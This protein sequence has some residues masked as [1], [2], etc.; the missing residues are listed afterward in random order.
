MTTETKPTLS[1][2]RLLIGAGAGGAVLAAGACG[3]VGFAARAQYEAELA[4]LRTLVGLYQQLEKVG[5]DGV[6]ASGMGV[7][8]AALDAVKTGV[9]LLRDGV[10]AVETAIKNFQG[11]LDILKTAANNASQ[12]LTEVIQ[13]TRAVEGPIIAVLGTAL[14]LAESISGFF[15]SL[16]GK[17][18]LGVGDDINKAISTLIDLIRSIPTTVDTISSK[19]L[20]PLR[21]MFFPTAGDSMAKT[22]L[23]DPIT[24]NLLEPL[25]SFLTDIESLIDKWEK[26]FS[27]PVQKALDERAQIR[28][29]IVAY[30][31]ETN[32]STNLASLR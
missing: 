2:R 1:R 18:P 3:A 19:L 9:R 14:P 8:R 29:K 11:A 32:P 10:T 6:I 28:Q 15:R 24:Q 7:V 31:E 26:D 20:A 21:D 12:V 27:A 16:I 13:K 23:F 30:L 22:R 25:K 5:L 4:K 17:I